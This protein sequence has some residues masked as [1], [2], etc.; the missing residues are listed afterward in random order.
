[1]L[2][3]FGALYHMTLEGHLGLDA[4]AELGWGRVGDLEVREERQLGRVEC[5]KGQG[6]RPG[7]GVKDS[8]IPGVQEYQVGLWG[9]GDLEVPA[10][11]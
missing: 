11:R 4:G 1:M 6:V 10:I 3:A 9:P 2:R 8:H 7:S 5:W